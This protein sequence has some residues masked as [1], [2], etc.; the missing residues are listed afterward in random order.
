M[1]PRKSNKSKAARREQA[2]KALE[3]AREAKK[4]KHLEKIKLAAIQ[5]GKDKKD[6]KLKD[7][8][9]CSDVSIDLEKCDDTLEGWKAKP[10]ELKEKDPILDH[11]SHEQPDQMD[12]LTEKDDPITSKGSSKIIETEHETSDGKLRCTR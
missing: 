12:L 9:N 7:K 6:S 3:K 1:K 10:I 4:K 2:N 11:D 8:F 5:A